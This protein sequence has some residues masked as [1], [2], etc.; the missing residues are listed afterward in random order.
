MTGCGAVAMW[1]ASRLCS[2]STR[3]GSTGLRAV[4][5]SLYDTSSL[6]R[7]LRDIHAATQHVAATGEG[8]RTLGA[9]L[10]GEELSA[11]DLF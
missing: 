11:M 8:Y 3:V 5:A 7:R 1:P 9:L 2:L 10:V 6:Q 4:S